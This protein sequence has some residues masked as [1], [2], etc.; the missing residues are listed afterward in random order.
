MKGILECIYE[1]LK[2]KSRAGRLWIAE[3]R[4]ILRQVDRRY[5]GLAASESVRWERIAIT[6]ELR[7]VW[8]NV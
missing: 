6:F 3:L 2:T 1:T 7:L 5:L 8:M 4:R